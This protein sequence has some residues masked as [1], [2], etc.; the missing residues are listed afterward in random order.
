MGH[1]PGKGRQNF[2]K[3]LCSRASKFPTNMHWPGGIDRRNNNSDLPE[4]KLYCWFHWIAILWTKLILPRKYNILFL[5]WTLIGNFC[6]I[7][8]AAAAPVFYIHSR[9]NK[10]EVNNT[11]RPLFIYHTVWPILIAKVTTNEL[12]IRFSGASEKIR[13]C[14]I[15]MLK[16]LGKP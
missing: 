8:A 6:K 9:G 7:A 12:K 11:V 2:A 3:F 13:F 1:Q 10:L 5:S 15:Y 4:W 14:N 16:T